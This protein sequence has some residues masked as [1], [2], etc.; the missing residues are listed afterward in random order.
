[1][2]K[3]MRLSN[4]KHPQEMATQLR[5]DRRSQVQ[6]LKREGRKGEALSREMDRRDWDYS[7]L[8][9]R[10]ERGKGDDQKGPDKFNRPAAAT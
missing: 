5:T 7:V 8:S 1:M 6:H 4:I 10:R 2:C 3:G 9:H